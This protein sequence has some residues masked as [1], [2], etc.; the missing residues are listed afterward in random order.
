MLRRLALSQQSSGQSVLLGALA[1]AAALLAAST[2]PALTAI[3]LI[4][5]LPVGLS[6]LKLQGRLR[7][8]SRL[9]RLPG[10]PAGDSVSQASVSPEPSPQRPPGS[11]G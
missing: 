3:P 8:D 4:L 5:G 11:A 9:D 10:V 6:W 7:R 2:R 1:V